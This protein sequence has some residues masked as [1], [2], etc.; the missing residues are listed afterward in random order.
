V[1]GAGH[2]PC[3]LAKP[4]TRNFKMGPKVPVGRD[5][6]PHVEAWLAGTVV[7]R[8]MMLSVADAAAWATTDAV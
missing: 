1:A 3:L 5:R 6:F 8:Q 4:V 2:L 7:H